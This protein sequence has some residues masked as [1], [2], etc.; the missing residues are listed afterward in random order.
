MFTPFAVNP[1]DPVKAPSPIAAGLTVAVKVTGVFC[2]TEAL[3]AVTVVVVLMKF[4]VSSN[5]ADEA[6]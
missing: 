3:D 5:D 1:I 6:A 4:I 2:V